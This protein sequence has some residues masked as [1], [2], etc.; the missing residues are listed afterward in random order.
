M[1]NG[2]D[3]QHATL[4]YV[5]GTGSGD[6]HTEPSGAEIDSE[7]DTQ[8]GGSYG[9]F[10]HAASQM[11]QQNVSYNEVELRWNYGTDGVADNDRVEVSVHAIE[12]VYI[13]KGSFEIGDGN[14]TND[15]KGSFEKS[16]NQSVT[17]TKNLTKGITSDDGGI[18]NDNK[19]TITSQGIGIDGTGGLDKDSDGNIE[20]ADFPTGYEAFYLMKYELSM[21]QYTEFL[22][23]IDNS[24]NRDNT[25]NNGNS[26][27]TISKS[28]GTFSTTTPNRACNYVN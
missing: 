3:W 10:I 20:N 22:N 4:N 28:G 2:S 5:D 16:S 19:S 14:G 25:S 23:K 9:V 21:G 13:P 17:I 8:S 26:G 24:T 15:S 11:N 1:K 18:P 6:G 12:M 27:F 7:D